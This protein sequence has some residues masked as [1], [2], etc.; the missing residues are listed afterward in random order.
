MVKWGKEVPYYERAVSG[1]A[2]M[3]SNFLD[4]GKGALF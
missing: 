2:I 1:F 3:L 4:D